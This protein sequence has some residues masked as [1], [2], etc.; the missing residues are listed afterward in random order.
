MVVV[1]TNDMFHQSSTNLLQKVW[2]LLAYQPPAI[3]DPLEFARLRCFIAGSGLAFVLLP[4]ALRISRDG[5]HV[6]R[7]IIA[8]TAS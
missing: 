4:M 7:T 6:Q 8:G 1:L 3:V 2:L 5:W